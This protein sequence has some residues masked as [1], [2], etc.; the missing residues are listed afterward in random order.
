MAMKTTITSLVMRLQPYK[1]AG[2]VAAAVLSAA[3][4]AA[5]APPEMRMTNVAAIEQSLAHEAAPRSDLKSLPELIGSYAV[6]GTDADG[7]PYARSGI[8]DI[9]LAPSGALELQ[10]D[11][12]K[13]VGVG[14]LAGN[15]LAVASTAK[16]RTMILVMTVNPD[17]TLSGKWSRR[18][19]RGARGTETWKK[20]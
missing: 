18:T 12:G 8:V 19:D 6:T 13:Q 2:V 16:G 9:Y 14:Q 20:M 4:L 11:N 17:G 15:M 7:M 10:W 1:C 3:A 5:G